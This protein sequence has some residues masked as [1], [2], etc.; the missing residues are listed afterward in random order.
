[1]IISIVQFISNSQDYLMTEGLIRI[2]RVNYIFLE[3]DWY[4]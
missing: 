4:C 2:E 1:M 3:C